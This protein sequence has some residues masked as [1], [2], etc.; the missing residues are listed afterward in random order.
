MSESDAQVAL[1]IARE[2]LD[3]SAPVLLGCR[4]ICGPIHRLGI[5][6]ETPFVTFIGV[7]SET[8]H[9][10]ID[11]EERKLWNAE[12]LVEMDKEIARAS[13][14]AKGMVLAASQA[15]VQRFGECG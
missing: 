8:D 12:V 11:P 10:P 13:E 9:L 14:W 3:G 15:V 5:D 2:I 4:R 7:E 6:R 1:R